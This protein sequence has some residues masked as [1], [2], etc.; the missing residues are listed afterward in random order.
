MAVGHTI[1]T[2]DGHDVLQ[3]V[4]QPVHRP[5]TDHPVP[6][7]AD[8]VVVGGG[9][10]AYC[11]AL[12]A[13]DGGAGVLM[14]E[15][16][17]FEEAGGNSRFAAGAIRCVYDGLDDLRALMPD[18]SDEEIARTEFGTYGEERF[19]DDM[20]RVTQYRCD[21][22]LTEL[23][24]RRSRETLRWMRTKG[25]RFQP[26][27][28]RQAFEIDGRF[29]FWGGLTIEA[30]GGGPGLVAGLS[31]AASKAD[32][33]IRYGTRAIELVLNGEHIEGLKVRRAGAV[34]IIRTGAVVLACGGFE[35]NHEWRARYLGPGWDLARV[36]GTRFNTGDG[37]RMA[38][39]I[40]AAPYGHWSGCHAVG[41]DRNAPDFGD[42][43]VGDG[44]QKHSYPFAES[45]VNATR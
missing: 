23:L 24:V 11:A 20:G 12:A 21:P 37:I 1:E 9:N 35:A 27:W 34:H 16:A 45:C 2:G 28:G 32:I 14:V 18:L 10:A 25:I 38:L 5:M 31:V 15:R 39:D 22:D 30:V 42:L 6:G 4:R 19:F 3:K 13:H 41:W 40:G 36:R 8:V 7:S 33:P 17:P 43:A 29:R 44:F 26:M